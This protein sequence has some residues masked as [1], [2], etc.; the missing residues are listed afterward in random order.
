M[1]IWIIVAWIYSIITAMFMG[2]G[3]ESARANHYHK[4]LSTYVIILI[5]SM[6]WPL[7]LIWYGIDGLKNR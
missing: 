1:S 4:D 5:S 7:T 6:L 3:M 2:S